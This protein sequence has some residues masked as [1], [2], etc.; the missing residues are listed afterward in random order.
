MGLPADVE[1]GVNRVDDALKEINY[2]ADGIIVSNHGGR[3]T[4]SAPATIRV[5]P[6]SPR[7]WARRPPSSSI[8]RSPRLRY[9][10]GAGARWQGGTDR[11]RDAVRDRGRRRGGGAAKVIQVI[12]TEMDKTMAY[13]GCNRVDEIR[14]TSSLAI[15]KATDRRPGDEWT[16]AS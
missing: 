1:T 4:D 5:L 14:P 16:L 12:Q 3:N 11:T 13:T 10:Q 7:R 15:G 2:G 6:E 8:R 9:R